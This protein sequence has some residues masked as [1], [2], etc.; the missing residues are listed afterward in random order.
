VDDLIDAQENPD[1]HRDLLVRVTGYSG[2][3]VDVPQKLQNDI[4]ERFK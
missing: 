3:F 4:I 1:L 2:V